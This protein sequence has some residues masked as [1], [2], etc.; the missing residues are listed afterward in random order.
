MKK[1]ETFQEMTRFSNLIH[2]LDE[3]EIEFLAM[4]ENDEKIKEMEK[5]KKVEKEL[6]DF[7]RSVPFSK[8]I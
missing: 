8:P 4:L 5:S 3:D 1:E 2:R 7:R 6:E